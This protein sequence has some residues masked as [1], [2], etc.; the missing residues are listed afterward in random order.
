MQLE[1]TDV[2]ETRDRAKELGCTHEMEFKVVDTT[3]PYNVLKLHTHFGWFEG[4]RFF[5]ACYYNHTFGVVKFFTSLPN[6][7]REWHSDILESTGQ[8]RPIR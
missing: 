6:G 7:G 2:Y 8:V 3:Y 1:M 4:K 5:E